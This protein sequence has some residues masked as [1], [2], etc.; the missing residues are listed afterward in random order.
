MAW[1]IYIAIYLFLAGAGAG[2]F[3]TAV[4]S[5]L[6]GR[7]SFH[8]LARAGYI[9]SGPMVALGMPFLI[10]DLGK[11]KTEPWRIINLYTNFGSVMTW[12]AWI[13]TFF[14]PVAIILGSFELDLDGLVEKY[15]YRYIKM[16]SLRRLIQ[17]VLR[18]WHELKKHRHGLLVFATALAFSTAIYT[19]LLIGVVKAVPLWNT[20][21]LPALFFIS[22]LSTGM[23]ASVVF[24]VL[25][26]MEE[27]RLLSEHFFYLNQVHSLLIVVE[28][29]FVF[30]WL[31]I[32]SSGSTVAG[33]SVSLLLTGN[34]AWLFW[35]GVIFFGII[36]PLMIYI[37]E[38][39]LGK[40]L[41]AYGMI[42]SDS[43][44][45][46]GGFVLRYLVLA[47]GVPVLLT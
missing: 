16:A 10:Y 45:L 30:C 42:I 40:P 18:I 44:V 24:A 22:A 11:G 21:I 6:Y 1:G 36:D 38:V 23:A 8:P 4:T 2:A 28:I 15:V 25:F 41:M 46:V 27:R 5:E 9:I 31:F 12:G 47:A 17:L 43:S 33:E 29:I 35:L 34:L 14:I 26:P 19:G 32:A 3:L 7:E 37:Y 20:T 39:V 13:L